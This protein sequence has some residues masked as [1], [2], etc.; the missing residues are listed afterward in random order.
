MLSVC[1]RRKHG[2]Q[3]APALEMVRAR[4]W[5]ASAPIRVGDI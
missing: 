4:T 5:R 3:I 1:A 2:K